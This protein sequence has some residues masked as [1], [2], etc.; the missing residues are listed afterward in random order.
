MPRPA[1]TR[2]TECSEVL[3]IATTAFDSTA[4]PALMLLES[5]CWIWLGKSARKMCGGGRKRAL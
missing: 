1:R 3:R 4:S 2:W 5:K